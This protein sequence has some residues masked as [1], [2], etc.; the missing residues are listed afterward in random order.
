MKIARDLAL[1]DA[2]L[3]LSLLVTLLAA[4][5]VAQAPSTSAGQ[6]SDASSVPS[7]PATEPAGIPAPRPAGTMSEL[8][9][10][11]IYPTSDSVFYI[12]TRT[13]S[14][15]A[16]WSE[17]QA[18]TLMLAESAN[19]LM[20][21]GRARDSDRWMT[22]AKLMFDAGLAAYRAA[23]AKNAAG[24]EAINDQLYQSCVQC[25]QHYRPGYGTR[26]P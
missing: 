20:M 25:H 19:L 14:S 21:P 18:R 3:V 6:A 5:G 2:G 8:M 23:R 16:E 24:L 26:R 22:D 1:R 4:R 15:D 10:R 7:A 17:L 11:I 12:G 9:I 13:P